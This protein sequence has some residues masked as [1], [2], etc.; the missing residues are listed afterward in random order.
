MTKKIEKF[1]N[2][3]ANFT[4]SEVFNSVT[5]AANQIIPSDAAIYEVDGKTVSFEFARIKE[6][7]D[8]K[9]LPTSEPTNSDDREGKKVSER[10]DHETKS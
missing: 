3:S 9:P 4:A 2:G 10:K 7:S 6:V 1:W 8:D 5:D